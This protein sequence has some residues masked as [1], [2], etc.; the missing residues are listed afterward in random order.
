MREPERYELREVLP[1]FV[2]LD[3]RG[4][5]QFTAAGL[6]IALFADSAEA[7]RGGGGKTLEAR[8]LIGKDG[9]VTILTGKVE[10]GQGARTEIGMAAAEELRLPLAKIDVVMADTD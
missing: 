4:F 1:H 5:I 9:R 2:E 7:Q 6:L 10:E 8:L 3:R